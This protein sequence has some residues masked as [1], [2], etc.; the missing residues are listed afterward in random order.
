MIVS[1]RPPVYVV[2]KVALIGA[3]AFT[4][5]CNQSDTELYFISYKE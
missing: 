3:A 1:P 5:V 4:F 2:P